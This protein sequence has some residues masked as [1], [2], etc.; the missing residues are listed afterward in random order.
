MPML[1]GPIETEIEFL[2]HMQHCVTTN[3][4]MCKVSKSQGRSLRLVS[5]PTTNSPTVIPP[6]WRA[7]RWH[8][9]QASSA[10]NNR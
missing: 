9:M 10:M 6:L 8:D 1:G 3:G 2:V 7:G 4:S 5:M